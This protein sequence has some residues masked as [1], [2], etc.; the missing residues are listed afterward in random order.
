V[1]SADDVALEV[2]AQDESVLALDAGGIAWPT[3]G[4]VDGGRGAQFDDRAVEREAMR[5]E[6][7]FAETDAVAVIIEQMRVVEQT[8]L[9]AVE[10]GIFNPHSSIAP[11]LL[12]FMVN[13]RFHESSPDGSSCVALAICRSPS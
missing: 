5:G 4:K 7:G 9:D 2:L 6:A 10:L 13:D 12:R 11:R 1:R 8:D 3:H